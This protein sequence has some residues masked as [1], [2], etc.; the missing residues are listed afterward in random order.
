[1]VPNQIVNDETLS[2]N[3]IGLLVYLLSKPSDWSVSLA[4]LASLNR[5]GGINKLS[6]DMA[7]LRASGYAQ[8]QRHRDG[9]VEWIVSDTPGDAAAMPHHQNSDLVI[10]PNHQKPNV[11]KPNVG[12]GDGIQSKEFNK[13]Q[14]PTN[15]PL[16]V[17]QGEVSD[18]D[19]PKKKRFNPLRMPI[20]DNIP[21]AVWE[22]LV[23]HRREIGKPMTERAAQMMAK[24][25]SE[26]AE[27][28]TN[29]QEAVAQTIRARYPDV[30]EPKCATRKK[31]EI[32][33]YSTDF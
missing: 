5:F 27:R 28:G 17:P 21:Q 33:W 3:H 1:V 30:Y 8:M 24:H 10:G 20:P 4:G 18:E 32:N 31:D 26:M 23:S 15:H 7:V 11:Q 9:S 29:I 22:D 25:L 19:A 12:F 13:V 16:L 6:R 14:S 2:G